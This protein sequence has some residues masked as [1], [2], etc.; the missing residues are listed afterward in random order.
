M[1]TTSNSH[2]NMFQVVDVKVHVVLDH[3]AAINAIDVVAVVAIF[4]HLVH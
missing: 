4:V 2:A 1:V 3:L